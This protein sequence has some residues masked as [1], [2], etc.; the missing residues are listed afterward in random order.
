[1]NCIVHDSPIGPLTLISDGAALLR[2]DF[3]RTQPRASAAARRGDAVLVAA[4]RQLDAYFKGKLHT[5]DLPLSAAG[6]PFQQRVW[7]AL[8]RIPYGETR[9]YRDIAESIGAPNAYRAVGL[10]NGR[11]PIAIVVPCH[12]VIGADGTLTGFGGGLE[13]KRQLL[14][15]E[16][17]AAVS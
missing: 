16:Q 3:G 10:A 7:A 11:N 13:R 4:R 2:L 5:F 15:L 8:S 6:T 17:G 12:R 14:D 9:S 1:M